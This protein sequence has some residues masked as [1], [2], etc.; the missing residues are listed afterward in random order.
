MCVSILMLFSDL[1]NTRFLVAAELLALGQ[2]TRAPGRMAYRRWGMRHVGR[3]RKP[4]SACR[5][6]QPIV[7][8]LNRI[9]GYCFSQRIVTEEKAKQSSTPGCERDSA[10][11]RAKGFFLR[12]NI[13]PID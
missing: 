13:V 1:L 8:N 5:M 7:L 2:V 3:H 10:I 12:V 6:A 4:R 11:S 9:V